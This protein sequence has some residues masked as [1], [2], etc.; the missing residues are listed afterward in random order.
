[1]AK[2]V[3]YRGLVKNKECW[4]PDSQLSHIPGVIL[5]EYKM[6]SESVQN[7][8]VCGAL[9]RLKDIYE[10]SMKQPA[11]LAIISISSYI[12][13][14]NDFIRMTSDELKMEHEKYISN[15]NF[16]LE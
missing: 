11:I 15:S 14:D 5:K 8:D 2:C 12:E 4:I 10:T 9:F 6:L 13:D 7:D 16:A 1:M 3:D